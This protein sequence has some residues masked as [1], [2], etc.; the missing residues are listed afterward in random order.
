MAEGEGAASRRAAG[1]PSRVDLVRT[2]IDAY[3]AGN[4][5]RFLELCH[6]D[7]HIR[8]DRRMAKQDT[9][10]GHAGLRRWIEEERSSFS[11][12]Y[13]HVSEIRE[14]EDGRVLMFGA[15]R[16]QRR[17]PGGESGM[18]IALLHSFEADRISEIQS[19]PSARGALLAAGLTVS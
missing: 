19:F 7:L 17:E 4:V 11:D 8:G 15:I 5:E 9:Y 3:N 18:F 16:A 12:F 10:E 14:L 1:S 13:V 6:P 2:A